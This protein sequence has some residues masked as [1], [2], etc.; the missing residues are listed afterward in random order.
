M[1]HAQDQSARTDASQVIDGLFHLPPEGIDPD[2]LPLPRFGL[3]SSIGSWAE[4]RERIAKLQADA[5]P[6]QKVKLVFVARHGQVR[7]SADCAVAD[8]LRARTTSLRRST[9]GRLSIASWPG[10]TRTVRDLFSRQADPAGEGLVW[11]PDPPLTELGEQV[12]CIER[13]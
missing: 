6:G 10:S 9:G 11:G 12:R 8:S 1:R 13:R 5:A 4:L 7:F 3:D 2:Q